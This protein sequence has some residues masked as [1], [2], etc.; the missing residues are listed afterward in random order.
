MSEKVRDP[1]SP[2]SAPDAGI[3]SR[4][5]G[6]VVRQLIDSLPAHFREAFVLRELNDMFRSH[7][8]FECERKFEH[9]PP[10]FLH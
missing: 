9:L 8:R 6:A 2:P 4:Q 5:K 7:I 10:L 1:D 3:L